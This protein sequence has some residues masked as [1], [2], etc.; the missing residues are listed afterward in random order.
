MDKLTLPIIN[1]LANER[2]HLYDIAAE[3]AL[4]FEQRQ[5]ITEITDKLPGLWDQYRREVAAQHG[6]ETRI[7]GVERLQMAVVKGWNNQE[8]EERQAA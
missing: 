4:T 1:K 8:K 7:S 5:R 3:H 6:P 2:Q